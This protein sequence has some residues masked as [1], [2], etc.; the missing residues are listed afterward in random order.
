MGGLLTRDAFR[1]AVFA[2]DGGR[3][4]VCGRPAQDAH[5]IMERRLFPDGGYYLDNGASL[6]GEHHVLAE[7]TEL[8]VE[9]IREACGIADA[10]L[11]EHLCDGD[12]YDKWGNPVLPSGGRGKGEL[13]GDPSVRRALGAAGALGLFRDRVK[14]PRTYHLPSSP[15]AGR[16]DRTLPSNEALEGRQVV[17]TVKMDGENTS[18][19]RDHAHARSL[20]SGRHESR[21]PVWDLQARIGH[22]I[23]EGWRVCGENLYARHTIHYRALPAWFLGFSVWD[24][25]NVCL[26]WDDTLEWL[27]LLGV[28]PVPAVYEGVWDEAA[29]LASLPDEC[30]G[31]PC[32]GLVVRVR[33]AFHYSRFRSSV[34]KW[35]AAEFRRELEADPGHFRPWYLRSVVPNRLA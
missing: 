4:V 30:C 31:G 2:R 33:D 22:E 25:G 3:C 13:F 1:D 5:H 28:E 16:G 7:T 12:R 24:D 35:V 26:G 32:E 34:A 9:E 14:Y 20:D 10:V 23:P 15:G 11:P 8:S 19:Y 27:A 18:V 29:V 17:A 6:C 21:W